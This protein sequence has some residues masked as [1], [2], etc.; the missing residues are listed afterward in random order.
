MR[1]AAEAPAA[2]T[3]I[4]AAR[5]AARERAWTL[6]GSQA[7]GSGGGRQIL[8]DIDAT[9]VT[10]CSEKEQAAPTWKK[11]YG[12]HLELRHRRR[13]RCEDP[14]RQGHWAAEPAA[15]RL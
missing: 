7:P 14:L 4:R 9:L 8:A 2:L 15:A 1:L 13:A 6:A 12:F 5:A 10:S 3:A 11:T